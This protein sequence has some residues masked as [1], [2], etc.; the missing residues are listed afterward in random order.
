MNSTPDPTHG[1][2][3]FTFYGLG[4][5][6]CRVDRS[7]IVHFLGLNVPSMSDRSRFP[8]SGDLI[9]YANSVAAITESGDTSVRRGEARRGSVVN[10]NIYTC[11]VVRNVRF[12]HSAIV[13][14]S[15]LSAYVSK[16]MTITAHANLIGTATARF[17]TGDGWRTRG[18]Q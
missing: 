1:T 8:W 15:H 10:I 18:V 16:K 11:G 12:S 7:F 3:L 9:V 13:T 2:G 5:V 4:R 17:I 14:G 6:K